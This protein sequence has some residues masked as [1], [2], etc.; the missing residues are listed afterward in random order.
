MYEKWVFKEGCIGWWFPKKPLKQD[1]WDKVREAYFPNF[2][3]LSVLKNVSNLNL[4]F[5]SRLRVNDITELN[6]VNVE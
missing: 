5:I 1:A 3:F 4:K 2:L 6:F